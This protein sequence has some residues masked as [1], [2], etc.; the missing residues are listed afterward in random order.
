MRNNMLSYEERLKL[1]LRDEV[2]RD[3]RYLKSNAWWKKPEYEK[4]VRELLLMISRKYKVNI[5]FEK[6]EVTDWGDLKE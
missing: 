2:I 4:Q 5:D 6:Y 1:K 3:L